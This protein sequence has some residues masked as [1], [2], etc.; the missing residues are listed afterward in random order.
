MHCLIE[1]FPHLLYSINEGIRTIE[2]AVSHVSQEVHGVTVGRAV[3]N[4]PWKA[5]AGAYT[6][7]L[8]YPTYRR[9]A[10]L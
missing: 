9:M 1:D 10:A 2:D 5:L 8:V 7:I 3:I 4:A 6:R